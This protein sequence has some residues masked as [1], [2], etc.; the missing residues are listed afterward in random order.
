MVLYCLLQFT[1]GVSFTFKGVRNIRCFKLFAESD[2]YVHAMYMISGIKEYSVSVNFYSPQWALLYSSS[3]KTREGKINI[4]T[5]E[6]GDYSLC[7]QS[8]DQSFTTVSFDL[9]SDNSLNEGEILTESEIFPLKN[10]LTQLSLNLRLVS[11]N[12]Q[13]YERREK[14]YRSIAKA[15]SERILWHAWFKLGVL[16]VISLLRVLA[17]TRLF[18]NSKQ[19]QV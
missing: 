19:V 3:Q 13:F 9:F 18:M 16:L 2:E 17:L 7:F 1:S 8:L 12:I 6:P 5:T 15:T 4:K 14:I 11:T 10:Q